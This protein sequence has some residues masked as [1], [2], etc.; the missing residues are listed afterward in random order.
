MNNTPLYIAGGAVLL[1]GLGYAWRLNRT[2]RNLETISRVR[3]AELTWKEVTLA[4]DTILKNPTNGK[5]KIK[6]PFV[7]VK[8][9]DYLIGSSTVQ[10]RDLEIPAHGELKINDLFIVSRIADLEAV[11]GEFFDYLLG[12]RSQVAVDVEIITELITAAGPVPIPPIKE[13]VK[14]S[15]T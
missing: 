13:Q 5:L 11:A 1:L 3:L 10:D 6:F 4:A 9:K 12:K 14:I 15:R 8:H 2:R 7:K